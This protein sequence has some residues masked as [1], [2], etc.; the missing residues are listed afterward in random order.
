MCKAFAPYGV[1]IL[2]SCVIKSAAYLVAAND[3]PQDTLLCPQFRLASSYVCYAWRSISLHVDSI[4]KVLVASRVLFFLS[5][6]AA[7]MCF[8]VLYRIPPWSELVTFSTMFQATG[9]IW[10]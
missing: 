4:R 3:H 10:L 1:L 6:M 5:L 9:H 8:G 7:E 2:N